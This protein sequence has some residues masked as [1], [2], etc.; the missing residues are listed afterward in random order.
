MEAILHIISRISVPK[1]ELEEHFQLALN[2]LYGIVGSAGIEY[3]IND[4]D[5]KTAK[6]SGEEK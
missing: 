3:A 5:G 1:K 6:V 2:S 4:Y